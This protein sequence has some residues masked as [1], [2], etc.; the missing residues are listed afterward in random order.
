[1]F[2]RKRPPRKPPPPCPEC[3]GPLSIEGTFCR[4]CGYDASLMDREDSYLDGVDLPAHPGEE[5]AG[6]R[7]PFLWTVVAV[8]LLLLLLRYWIV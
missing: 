4:K 7:R 6:P 8:L 2:S 1:M 5:S 3:G